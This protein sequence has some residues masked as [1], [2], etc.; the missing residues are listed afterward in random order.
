M[1]S[2]SITFAASGS[3]PAERAEPQEQNRSLHQSALTGLDDLAAA[4]AAAPDAELAADELRGAVQRAYRR[5]SR[6]MRRACDAAPGQA[7]DVSLHDARKAA[8]RARY[9]AEV[10]ASV[11]GPDAMRLARKLRSVQAVLGEHQDTVIARRAVRQL[12]ISAHLS[13]ENAF[14][15]G[16]L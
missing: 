5:T 4:P 11:S 8:K 7:T 10:V 12:G 15:Y 14:S 1:S 9:A 13:G 2:A 16:L 3:E 6:R